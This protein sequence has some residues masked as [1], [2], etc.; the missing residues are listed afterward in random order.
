MPRDV[1]YHRVRAAAL[2]A[3]GDF[4]GAATAARRA[5]DLLDGRAAGE[6]AAARSALEAELA[7]YRD[8]QPY[9]RNP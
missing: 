8:R 4:D 3:T 1:R 6:E 7:R 2:A 5:L 9:P